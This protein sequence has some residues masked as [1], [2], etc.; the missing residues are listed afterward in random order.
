MLHE[1]NRTRPIF[2]RVGALPSRQSGKLKIAHGVA[3]MVTAIAIA[4]V[5][6]LIL[7]PHYEERERFGTPDVERLLPLAQLDTQGLEV[8]EGR[9]N[10]GPIGRFSSFERDVKILVGASMVAYDRGDTEAFL[11]AT[12][13]GIEVPAELEARFEWWRGEIEDGAVQM[14]GWYTQ[15]DDAVKNVSMSGAVSDGVLQLEGARGPRDCSIQAAS[16]PL[17]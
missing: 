17:E 10:C 1:S 7:I 6:E 12:E 2:S 8:W 3:I 14:Y 4:A 16:G 9:L 11:T 15:G 13:G 5:I